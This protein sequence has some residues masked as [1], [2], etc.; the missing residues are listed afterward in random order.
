MYLLAHRSV[1]EDYIEG[2][3]L[4]AYSTGFISLDKQF[5]TIGINGML[6]ASEVVKG[7]AD[8]D[9]FSWYLKEQQFTTF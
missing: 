6:E 9:F 7:K 1:I 5:C 3:L 4:P 8:T 2:G